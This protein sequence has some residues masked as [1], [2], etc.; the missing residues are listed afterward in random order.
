M[1]Y[2]LRLEQQLDVL[3]LLSDGS[4]ISTVS[5]FTGIHR[6][7]CSRL[8]I[9]FSE[10]CKRL[11]DREMRDLV[12]HH[13]EVDEIWTY[14]RKK[15]RKVTGAE[16]DHGAIGDIYI[17][18]ALDEQTRLVPTYLV[19]RRDWGSTYAFILDLASRLKDM[20]DPHESDDHGYEKKRYPIITR[21]SSDAF[22]SYEDAIALVFGPYVEYAQLVKKS[23]A[24]NGT[25]SIRK[26][27]I[28]GK[29]PPEDVST[30]LVERNNLTIRTL[31]KRLARRTLAFSKKLQNLEAAAAL[32]F[33]NYNF[34]WMHKTLK[35]TPAAFAGVVPHPFTFRF[36][37]NTIRD[38]WPEL[39]LDLKKAS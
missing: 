26:R 37:F 9:R 38:S 6:D 2:I 22:S 20:P 8:M 7:T 10:G 5:R 12:L 35:T 18:V 25:M 29:V 11:L 19:G 34:C 32:H 4:S 33:C 30:S 21:I 36:L 14:C 16:P 17:F 31:M 3:K 15:E 13:I 28:Q 27:Q 23:I 39:F 24:K 1:A